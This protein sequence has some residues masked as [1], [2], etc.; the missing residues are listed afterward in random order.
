[1][2]SNEVLRLDG[3][4][5]WHINFGKALLTQRGGWTLRDIV[6]EEEVAVFPGSVNPR[7]AAELE[8]WD[9][10]SD[11]ALANFEAALR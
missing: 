9:A 1:M 11:E 3:N 6:G 4:S 10:A 8:A 2:N 5:P 7:L